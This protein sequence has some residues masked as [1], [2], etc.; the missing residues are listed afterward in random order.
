[1]SHFFLGSYGFRPGRGCHDAIKALS[2][3]L[4]KKEVEVVIDVDIANFF[5]T[6]SHIRLKELLQTKI[7]DQKF[8]RY[9]SR[10]FKAGVLTD[11]D[12]VVSEEGVA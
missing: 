8:M 10:M 5:G 7:T 6:I 3:H 4:Y 12:L 1:M 11:G 9:I 2:E